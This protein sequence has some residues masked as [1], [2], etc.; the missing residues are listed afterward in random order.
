MYTDKWQVS[1]IEEMSDRGKEK[2]SS[3][4]LTAEA[5]GFVMKICSS[6]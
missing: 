1:P 6:F 3:H 5:E 4:R 2:G